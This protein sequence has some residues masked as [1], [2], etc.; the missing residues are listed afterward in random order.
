MSNQQDNYIIEKLVGVAK[1]SKTCRE[2]AKC[3]IICPIC[4]MN[5]KGGSLKKHLISHKKKYKKKLSKLTLNQNLT[6]NIIPCS[7]KREKT[8]VSF[9][10][11]RGVDE[12][13]KGEDF[14]NEN[15][16]TK[17]KG[18]MIKD[19]KIL[20]NIKKYDLLREIAL[21]IKRFEYYFSIVEKNPFIFDESLD[22][23]NE[24]QFDCKFKHYFP[25]S[26]P[27]NNV[28]DKKEGNTQKEIYKEFNAVETNPEQEKILE[29]KK[30]N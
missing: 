11:N 10:V 17:I 18:F 26:N 30:F 5:L 27:K 22:L 19:K 4:M 21:N 25:K 16:L 29:K 7:N 23:E 9:D 24:K 15:R 3:D 12:E 28:L 20:S 13:F 1:G 14:K 8:L 6:S 2:F